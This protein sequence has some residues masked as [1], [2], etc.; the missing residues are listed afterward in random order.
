MKGVARIFLLAALGAVACSGQGITVTSPNGGENWTLGGQR[1]ITWLAQGVSGNVRIVLDRDGAK[2]GD[3]AANVPASQQRF[4]WTVGALAGG[5]QAP[6]GN[7][8]RVRIRAMGTDISDGSN[9]DF[10]LSRDIHFQEQGGHELQPGQAQGQAPAVRPGQNR[11]PD[12]SGLSGMPDVAITEFA[13]LPGQHIIRGRLESVGVVPYN[14]FVRCRLETAEGGCWGG[15]QRLHMPK[16][17]RDGAFIVTF[18]PCD[19]FP[20]PCGHAFRLAIDPEGP[21]ERSDN[22][23]RDAVFYRFHGMHFMPFPP[24][25]LEF[26]HGS[27][28][29]ECS[30]FVY[31]AA[32]T[33]ARSDVQNDYDPGTRSA[34]VRFVV[35]VRNCGNAGSSGTISLLLQRDV[36]ATVEEI[37]CGT[38][39]RSRLEPGAE[40]RFEVTVDVPV[41]PGPYYAQVGSPGETGPGETCTAAFKFADEFFE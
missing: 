27:K 2:L 3:I 18:G 38:F 25:R 13:Y 39:P 14:G 6:A 21:D 30:R 4:L 11:P 32:N 8:Y 33:I 12:M 29:L 31:D 15:E 10:R 5:G 26:S 24:V 34:Q 37:F 40:G 35:G 22:N 9:A 17:W 7:G 16:D 41:R 36:G 23:A 28:Q 20:A 19:F 1:A